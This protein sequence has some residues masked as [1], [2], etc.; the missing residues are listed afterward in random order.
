M[1]RRIRNSI[2]QSRD[3]V[4]GCVFKSINI[5]RRHRRLTSHRKLII[6]QEID[7]AQGLL[8]L[9]Q[10]GIIP[11]MESQ[12]VVNRPLRDRVNPNGH[13][14][15][16]EAGI[17]RSRRQQLVVDLDVLQRQIRLLMIQRENGV[18][19]QK[20]REPDGVSHWNKG[21]RIGRKNGIV[22]VEPAKRP[23]GGSHA[24]IRHEGAKRVELSQRIRRRNCPRKGSRV[25]ESHGIS[26][27][28]PIGQFAAHP[29]TSRRKLH[30][31][32]H[33]SL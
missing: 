23:T 8:K 3:E 21:A 31:R 4:S 17:T 32:K 24:K 30:A 16:D 11:S 12:S 33:C 2:D 15:A 19:R 27:L 7:P 5:A 13:Q 14:A 6:G 26:D 28:L 10:L 29:V 9:G 18:E 22:E 1:R 20:L 25:I